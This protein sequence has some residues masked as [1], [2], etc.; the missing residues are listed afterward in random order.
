M[1]PIFMSWLPALRLVYTRL[2]IRLYT[3]LY[4]RL[5]CETSKLLERYTICLKEKSPYFFLSSVFLYVCLSNL[6]R[7]S[8]KHYQRWLSIHHQVFVFI[9]RIPSDAALGGG[10]MVETRAKT[11]RL[12]KDEVHVELSK[13]NMKPHFHKMNNTLKT[14]KA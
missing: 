4:T 7:I 2:Y 14:A 10:G 1:Y 8:Q 5:C 6:R 13:D 11:G 3:R 12:Q 9:V